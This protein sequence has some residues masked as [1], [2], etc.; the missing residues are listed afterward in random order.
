MPVSVLATLEKP[1][2]PLTSMRLLVACIVVAV[3]IPVALAVW[4]HRGTRPSR[5]AMAGFVVAVLIGQGA[6]V[7][8]VAL[9]VNRDYGFYPDWSSLLGTGLAP[10]VVIH[11]TRLG[12]N[13]QVASHRPVLRVS[14]PASETG[15]Y[16]RVI[17][18]G[19]K[20][21]ITQTVIAWLP[22]QY[23]DRRYDKTRFPVVMVLGG[24]D[25]RI[26]YVVQRL[27]FAR[28]ASAEIRSGRVAPFVAVFPEINVALPVD[29][30]CT[31]YPGSTQA[32]TWLDQ[33]VTHWAASTLRV[34]TEARQWSVMG[35]STG[36]YCAALL[37]LRDPGRF[38][39]AASVEGY[40]TPEPD[41]T[42]GN[43]GWLLRHDLPLAHLS[44]P[45]W[46]IEH[47][48]PHPTRLLVMTSDKD[49]QSRPQ[50]MEFL[51]A[52]PNVT[53]IQPYLPKGLGHSLDAYTAVLAPVLG[54]LAQVA[55]A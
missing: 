11:G 50:S 6:T 31:D 10:P 20:S 14:E 52:E 4:W 29:T 40:F 47:R 28:V 30:E 35:W 21:G 44:S 42:T 46:L 12:L 54:W 3:G 49:P 13:G 41:S 18:R 45:Q 39:A 15:R 53:G 2:L 32:F 7:A 9:D 26:A 27:N 8:A 36:G 1:A 25:V 55:D 17:L 33:D 43:L 16:E 37:H 22:P 38:G 5:W 24:A 48:P 51:R 34:S 23:G 19:A